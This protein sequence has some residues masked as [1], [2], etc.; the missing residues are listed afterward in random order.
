[1]QT[2]IFGYVKEGFE[3]IKTAFEGNFEKRKEVGA[4]CC[5]YYRGEKVVDL[6][7]GFRDKRRKQYWEEDTVGV[8]FS[9]TKGMSSLAF[10]ILHSKGLLDFDE[11]VAAYWPEFAFNNKQNITVRQLLAHQAGLFTNDK[12]LSYD[13]L[14]DANRLSDCL[15]K[16]KPY[17]TPG[18]KKG[19]HA[20]TIAMYQNELCKRID[21][22]KKPLHRFFKDEIADALD[23]DFHIG[24][25][26]HIPQHRI[27]ELIPFFPTEALTGDNNNDINEI[28]KGVLNPFSYFYKSLLNP[29]HAINLNNFNKRKFVSIP[30]GSAHGFGNARSLAQAYNEFATGGKNLHL[31]KETLAELEAAPIHPKHGK[32]DLVLH[33]DIPFSLGFAKP[34]AYQNFGVN[35]RSYGTFG[36]GGSGGFA[37]PEKQVAFGY[38]MNKMGTHIANDPRELAL[39]NATYD[40]IIALENKEQNSGSCS[41]AMSC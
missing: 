8:V 41:V 39:R 16:Q 33:V 37:D 9:S 22:F 27:A 24:L 36:A 3:N 5:V 18:E 12:S 6:W 15:A 17:W 21:P 10:S 20:W 7:G 32:N 1:M 29:P 31:R 11:K 26:E 13:I 19:Y 30:N 40:C 28:M 34:S 35:Y 4:C 14:T 38:V 23:I 25:P 2:P